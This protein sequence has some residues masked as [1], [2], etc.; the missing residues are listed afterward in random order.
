MI[1]IIFAFLSALFAA[2]VAIF[3]KIGLENIDSTLAT[4]VRGIIMALFLVVVTLIMGKLSISGV[5]AISQ[6]AWLFIALSGV[7]GALSWLFYFAA[8]QGGTTSVVVAIDNLAIVFVVMFAGFF[9]SESFTWSSI[10]GSLLMA[11]GAVLIALR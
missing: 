1:P 4:T 8:I 9:L 6:K 10:A 3:G 11:G 7:A 5:G 2:L